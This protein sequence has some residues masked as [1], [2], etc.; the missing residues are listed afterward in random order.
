MQSKSASKHLHRIPTGL[1]VA[2]GLVLLVATVVLTTLVAV[3]RSTND[4]PA[5]GKPSIAV[6]HP[7]ANPR[8]SEINELHDVSKRSMIEPDGTRA[9]ANQ[10]DRMKFR[11]MN[12]QPGEVALVPPT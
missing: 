11:E 9:T 1:A 12:G 6:I 7:R 10:F 5:A 3:D 8:F 2:T 4:I